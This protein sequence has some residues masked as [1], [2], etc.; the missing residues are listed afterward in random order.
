MSYGP[1]RLY[2]AAHYYGKSGYFKQRAPRFGLTCRYATDKAQG[3]VPPLPKTGQPCPKPQPGFEKQPKK[4]GTGFGTTLAVLGVGTAAIVAY[5][6][7]DCDFRKYIETNAPAFNEFIKVATQEEHTYGEN[8]DRLLKYVVG[9]FG[10]GE[11]QQKVTSADK[12]APICPPPVK[13]EPYEAP[14][15]AFQPLLD[16]TPLPKDSPKYNEIR[17]V[18][19][20]SPELPKPDIV[21]LEDTAR[22]PSKD[23]IDS[24]PDFHP[25]NVVELEKHIAESAKLSID[26]YEKAVC[27]LRDHAETVYT[28]LETKIDRV[29]PSF[30]NTL[31]H[32]TEEKDKLIRDAEKAALLADERIK[33]LQSILEE[34]AF[35][36]PDSLKNQARR[37]IF[38]VLK[39]IERAKRELAKERERTDLTDK[40]WQKVEQARRHFQEEI[41]ILFPSI[42]LDEKKLDIKPGELDLLLIHAYHHVLYYQK[43]LSK[44]ETLGEFR[45]K[46][47]LEKEG[48]GPTN[49]KL[50][51]TRV[52]QELE[53]EKRDLYKDLQRKILTVRAEQERDIKLQMKRQLEAAEDYLHDVMEAKEKETAR[54]HQRQIDEKVEVERHAY[55]TKLAEIIGRMKG[56]E[57]SLM[58]RLKTD[59]LATQAQLLFACCHQLY[60]ALRAGVPGAHWSKELRPLEPEISAIERAIGENDQ[61][62]SAVLKGI[63]SEARKRGVFP[64]VA[65]RERFL[66]VE[67][68]ARKLALIP[69]D[70]GSLPRYFLSYLQSFLLFRSAN[71]I[72]TSELDDQPVD[73]SKLDTYDLLERARYWIDRG[74]FGMALRYMNLLKGAPRTMACEWMK[75]TRIFLETQ[76]AADALMAYAAA[77]GQQY[78]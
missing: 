44:L 13:K 49:E 6:K 38:K 20:P 67:R 50:I 14:K 12:K 35:G 16:E 71:P 64:E 73:V 5:A 18:Q 36:A 66:K 2:L 77:T 53:K 43:E 45:V 30:W 15:S 17:V 78:T 9:M 76:Q 47:A 48:D 22:P 31:K 34:P 39:D 52:N 40:Y 11:Q 29:E 62:V 70:G 8:W 26:A 21:V 10:G 58:N 42:K 54:K 61:L 69:E 23:F 7:Y 19:P 37:N 56:V 68:V 60:R 75:E 65:L 57:H 28:L 27:G 33:K 55:N 51:R 74:D 25:K 63:P 32:K 1:S 46:Q 24:L 41:E 59:E 4:K 3:S 72:P